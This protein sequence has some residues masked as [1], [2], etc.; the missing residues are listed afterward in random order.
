[1]KVL[2]RRSFNVLTLQQTMDIQYTCAG[3]MMP[4][5]PGKDIADIVTSSGSIK[6]LNNVGQEYQSL[7]FRQRKQL[8]IKM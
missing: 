3:A 8:E 1:M 5:V 7:V 6:F 4:M 2:L